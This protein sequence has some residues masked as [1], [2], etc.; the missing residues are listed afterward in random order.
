MAGVTFQVAITASLLVKGRTGELSITRLTPEGYED[1]DV[2]FKDETR[3]L[4]QVKERSP[5]NRFTRSNLSDALSKKVITL[6]EDADCHFVLAT[7]ATLGRGL[8][9]TGWDRTLS[10]C[11]E[12]G[13]VEKL[14]EQLE[15]FFDDPYEVLRRTHILGIG[16][17]VVER[18]RHDFAQTLGTHPSVAALSYARLVEQIM[19]ISIRQRHATPDSA[20]W[21]APTDLDALATRVLETVDVESLEE[22]VR[23]GIV[24]PVDFSVRADLSQQDFLA[25]VDVLPSHIAADLD[26]P[27][28]VELS[29]IMSALEDQHSAILTGPSGSGKSALLWRTA[30]ELAGHVRTY[31]LL[32]LLPEDV[33]PLSRWIRLQEPSKNSPLL[34]CADNLGRPATA[35][36]TNVA[37]EFLDNPGVLFLGACREEDYRPELAVGRTTIVDPKLDRKLAISIADTLANRQVQTTLDVAEAHEASDGLL[38]EFLSMLLTGRRLQQV[39]AEQVSARLVEGRTTEREILRYVT[40]AHAAGVSLPAEVLG[41]MIRGLDLPPALTRLD[42]EH[43]LTSDEEGRWQGLHELRSRIVR[44]SLH[45]LPPPTLATTV[46]NLVEHLPARDASRIIEEYAR[47]DAD[48]V[49]TAEAVSRL[50]NSGSVGPEEGAQLVSGLAVADAFRHAQACLIVI[51]KLRPSKLDPETVLLLAYSHRFA[52]VSL[53]SLADSNP[54]ISHL[55]A[56]AE[57]L[58]DRPPSLREMALGKLSSESI[59]DITTTGTLNQAIRWLESLEG[60]LPEDVAPTSD[61]WKHFHRAPLEAAARLC[62]TLTSLT[63]GESVTWIADLWGDFHHRT[64]WLARDLLNCVSIES[65]DEPDGRSVTLHLLAPTDD[66]DLEDLSVQVCRLVFD[67]CPEVDIVEVIVLNSSGERYSIGGIEPGRK[68]IPRLNLPRTPMTADNPRFIQAGRLLLASSYWTEPIRL[69]AQTSKQLLDL[70]DDAITWLTNPYHNKGRRRK[71]VEFT[72]SLTASL[73]AGP[74][75]PVK[76]NDTTGRKS[77]KDAL[78]DAVSVVR[79]IAASKSPDDFEQ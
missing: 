40:T 76:A 35:G 17:D 57:A 18:S 72:N 59:Q 56:L 16:W 22:A 39:I 52:G 73:A 50:L 64:D 66:A 78:N 23:A 26:L 48:L 38:M 14:A 9:P 42:R 21:I 27:R 15:D 44:D 79:D 7:N 43:I 58:P 75:E 54:G 25:G 13:E 29:A 69:L 1:I 51:E 61:I 47:L 62:A 11:V 71:A 49:P 55:I 6:T 41:T 34:I 24:E 30:R 32:R 12:H 37:R 74:K 33:P 63:S 36:W 20:M 4:I 8:S 68:R 46:Q 19:E 70:R 60:S 10:D 45:K 5:A 65:R 31:R 28:P 2:E 53:D 67:L 77:A 3:M